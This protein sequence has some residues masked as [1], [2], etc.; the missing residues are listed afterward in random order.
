VVVSTAILSLLGLTVALATLSDLLS[1][2]TF[3]LHLFFLVSARLQHWTISSAYSLFLLF[4]G[5][6]WNVLKERIDSQQFSLDQLLLGTV[7][8]TCLIFLYPTF[9]FY[10]LLFLAVP[11][12][13]HFFSYV[14]NV[15]KDCG[16]TS[17]VST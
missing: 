10:Y 9:L 14:A 3:H 11:F 8:F 5:K 2:T 12:C 13:I 6:K 1:F 17:P 7:L 15:G 16:N 4:R